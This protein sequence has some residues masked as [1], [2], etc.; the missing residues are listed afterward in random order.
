MKTML[1]VLISVCAAAAFGLSVEKIQDV[2][3]AGEHDLSATWLQTHWKKAT[4]KNLRL[5]KP[6]EPFR[7]NAVYLGK[8]A[9][10]KGLVS[11]EETARAGSDGFVLKITEDAIGIASESPWGLLCGVGR[12]GEML[13]L[14]PTGN[15]AGVVPPSVPPREL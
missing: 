14:R 12:L 1:S 8:A 15:G 13:G 6:S 5:L 11:K 2:H 7:S 9:L 3:G 10:E 4:G